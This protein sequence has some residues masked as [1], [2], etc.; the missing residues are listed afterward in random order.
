MGGR[1]GVRRDPRR[2]GSRR[3]QARAAGHRRPRAHLPGAVRRGH[4]GQPDLRDRQPLEAQRR[5]R[6]AGAGGPGPRPRAARRRR[7]VRHQP[8]PR[9]PRALGPR[10]RR[11][12]GPEPAD[13]LPADHRLRHGGP[14]RGPARLRH[15][16][17]LGPL[18]RGRPAPCPRRPA[19]VPARRHGRSPHRQLGGRRRLRRAVQPRAHRRGPAHLHLPRAPGRLHDRLRPRRHPRVGRPHRHRLAASRWATRP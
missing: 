15:R 3:H 17:L 13:R 7:R 2:L 12:A 11:G 5:R 14:R 10:A 8:A 4:A 1:P 9:R 19:A 18:R 6:P 16:W